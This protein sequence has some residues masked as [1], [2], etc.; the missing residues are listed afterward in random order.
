MAHTLTEPIELV[1]QTKRPKSAFKVVLAC[2]ARLERDQATIAASRTDIA[3]D[4]GISVQEVSTVMGE[5]AAARIVSIEH[6]GRRAVYRMNPSVAWR[7][8]EVARLAEVRD[9]EPAQ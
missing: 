3:R 1:E 5:L 2:L 7:G 6:V 8:R 4:C 9:F